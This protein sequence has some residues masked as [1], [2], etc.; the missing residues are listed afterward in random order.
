MFDPEYYFSEYM[1]RDLSTGVER[2]ASGRFRDFADLT[3][4][5]EVVEGSAVNAERQMYYCVNV[6]AEAPWAQD[7]YRRMQPGI[8]AKYNFSTTFTYFLNDWANKSNMRIIFL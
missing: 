3:P 8:L 4:R 5:E 1:V 6:P 2:R 7:A